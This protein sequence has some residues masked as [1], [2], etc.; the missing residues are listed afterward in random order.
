LILVLVLVA[1][2]FLQLSV[3][4]PEQ[5]VPERSSGELLAIAR[6][7]L[8]ELQ[9]QNE[10]LDAVTKAIQQAAATTKGAPQGGIEVKLPDPKPPEESPWSGWGL[11]FRLVFIVTIVL[12][13]LLLLISY[14]LS[15]FDVVPFSFTGRGL[16]VAGGI[17]GSMLVG[18]LTLGGISLIKNAT[19]EFTLFGSGKKETATKIE[20]MLQGAA[21]AGV[22]GPPGPPGTRG[23]IGERGP[24]GER[25]PVGER[26]STGERGPIGE[27]GP[28]GERG[29]VGDRGPI[30]ERGPMGERGLVGEPARRG[31]S[32]FV[33]FC[34]PR[35]P[36]RKPHFRP[37]KPPPN[38]C[39]PQPL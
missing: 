15:L 13:P 10:R 6:S 8:S 33:T 12:I 1:Q 26:G 5:A 23:P 30:G 25:G 29:S 24:T 9:I 16:A 4:R 37:R 39:A 38:I 27:R 35:M 31:A 36:P 14:V 22:Q 7:G 32:R 20:V 3:A 28:T 11:I 19:L 17:T 2:G 34:R 21:G 18:T